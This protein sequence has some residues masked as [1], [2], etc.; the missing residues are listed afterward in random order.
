M[1]LYRIGDDGEPVRDIQQRLA[2]L[3]FDTGPDTAGAFEKGTEAAVVA[4]QRH[5]GL[6][7]DGIVGPDTWRALVGAGYRLGDRLLYHRVPMMRG[8]DVAD[9]QRKLDALGFETGKPDGIFGPDTLVGLLDFQAN[10]RLPEDGIAGK[11]VAAELDRMAMATGKPGRDR[12]R[13]QQWIAS[14]PGTLIGQRIYVDPFCRSPQE[15]KASWT[16]ARIF[17]N[18]IQDLGAHPMLSRSVDTAP[19]PRVRAVRA[20]RLG[21]D[22]V[23]AFGLPDSDPPGVFYFGSAISHSAAG[24]SLASPIAARLGLSVAA[25]TFPILKDT[26]SPAVAISTESLDDMTGG[27]TA[28][29]VIDLFASEREPGSAEGSAL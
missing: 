29:G 11:E 20:N 8:D 16:A 2:A 14:L 18:I 17:A 23:V 25:R 24:R 21:V 10:R 19:N 3:G 5:N 27:A 12:V 7:A 28:Q 1:R 4:F 13:Q 22:F 26:R 9:L 15:S 6:P